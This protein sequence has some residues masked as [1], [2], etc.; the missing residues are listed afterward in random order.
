M[1]TTKTPKNEP[2]VVRSKQPSKDDLRVARE[3]HTLVQ[4]I[5]C[6]LAMTRPWVPPPSAVMDF[7]TATE[8]LTGMP[9]VKPDVGLPGYR[10]W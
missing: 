10:P 9:W 1:T 8:P 4:M 5:Y 7:P 2:E 3:A 6:E